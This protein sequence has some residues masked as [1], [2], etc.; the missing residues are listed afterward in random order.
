MRILII[1]PSRA[2]QGILSSLLQEYNFAVDCCSSGNQALHQLK[3][4]NYVLVCS[5]LHL[6]DMSA[7]EFCSQLRKHSSTTQLPAILLTSEEDT[8]LRNHALEVGFTEVFGKSEQT[9]ITEYIAALKQQLSNQNSLHGRVLLVE[10]SLLISA[11][12]SAL[13]S[14][15]NLEVDAY[16]CAEEAL[17]ALKKTRYDLII[18]DIVLAGKMN[19]H[20]FL[21]AVRQQKP[22]VSNL[23]FLAMSAFSDPSRRVEIIKNGANDFI[24][25]PILDEELLARTKNLIINKQLMDQ[26]KDQQ[27]ELTKLAMTDQLTGLYNRHFL[28][29]MISKYI[30]DA[31]RHQRPLSIMVMDLDHFKKI[32]DGYGHAAGDLVL[33]SVAKVIMSSCREGDIAARFGG[34][35]FVLVL[36]DCPLSGAT[37]KAESLRKAI[38]SLQPA[39][40]NITISIGL[41]ELPAG[42]KKPSFEMLF[43]AADAALYEAKESGRNRVNT[44]PVPTS[45]TLH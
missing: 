36:P 10:D 42:T 2:Y 41:T 29:N 21:R 22:P 27:T 15:L 35:E 28:T 18:S 26:I 1:E 13:L 34:E 24:I 43:S 33:T 31:Q 12:V 11:Q 9:E 19:G 23:P 20:G 6:K 30:A 7:T 16:I 37:A 14:T 39:G 4:Q 8:A 38:S 44:N 17:S 40:L 25:K 32:N 5:A 3:C 45:G